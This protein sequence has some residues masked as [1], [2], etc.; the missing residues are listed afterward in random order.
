MAANLA[1]AASARTGAY[2]VGTGVETTV[3]GLAA[4]LRE[5]GGGAPFAV[6]HAPERTGEVHRSCVD[7]S[8][9][10]GALGWEAQVALPEGLEL[11]LAPLRG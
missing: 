1:A 7:P 8:L 4:A 10:R 6:E 3:L 11:T 5:L 2:N 9:A